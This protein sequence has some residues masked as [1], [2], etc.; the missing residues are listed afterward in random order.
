MAR[1]KRIST[2]RRT[3]WGGPLRFENTNMNKFS[4]TANRC[5]KLG[6]TFDIKWR[7]GGPGLFPK[8]W[9]ATGGKFGFGPKKGKVETLHPSL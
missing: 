8:L 5:L 9:R 4:R 6:G 3:A 1:R 2:Q 7:R